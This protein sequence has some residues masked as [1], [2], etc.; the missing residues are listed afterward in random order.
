MR[1]TLSVTA[2]ISVITPIL[3]LSSFCDTLALQCNYGSTGAKYT[4]FNRF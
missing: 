1:V 2:Y 3:H 4:H